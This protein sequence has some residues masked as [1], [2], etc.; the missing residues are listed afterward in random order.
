M[1]K[2]RSKLLWRAAGL[3]V[4]EYVLLDGSSDLAQVEA[5]LGL[6]LFVKP[7]CEGS[8]IGITKVL[9]PG[10]LGAAYA[11]AAKHDSLVI[12]ERAILGGEYTVAILGD[13]AL[14]I[15]KI[16]PSGEFY[17]YEAKYLRDDTAYLCPCGLPEGREKRASRAGPRGLPDPWRPR[18]GAGRFPDGPGQRS[19]RRS[20]L[21]SRGKHL[22]RV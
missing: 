10:E 9:R 22:A 13:Q 12:A 4:P 16:E 17:D 5:E 20:G 15:I 6:P 14:P 21:L 8:S 2:W 19:G 11:A 3:P 7:A 1:D 18:L